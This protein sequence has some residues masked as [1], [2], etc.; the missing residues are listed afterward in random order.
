LSNVPTSPNQLLQS[1]IQYHQ[2]GRLAEAEQLY[3]K[4]LAQQPDHADALYLLGRLAAQVGRYG[5]AADLIGQA[6]ALRPDFPEAYCDLG[7]ALYGTGQLDEAICAYRQAIALRPQYA[8]AYSNLGDALKVKGQAEEAIAACRHAVVL[9]S[10][11]PEAHYNLG[12]ALTMKAR[13]DEAIIAYRQAIALRPNYPEAY[14]NLGVAL[15]GKGQLDE[16]IAA[17]R[18][19]LAQRPNY[20]EAHNNLGDAL[21]VKGQLDEAI[22]ACRQSIALRPANPDAYNNLGNALRLNGQLD[23]AIAAYRQAVALSPGNGGYHSNLVLTLGYHPRFDARALNDEAQIWSC[24]HA[25]PLRKCIRPHPNDRTPGRRLRIGYVSADFQVHACALFLEPLLRS[26]DQSQ[27]EVFCYSQVASPDSLTRRFQ[28]LCT[29]WRSTVGLSDAQVAD[30]VREDGID[31]LVDLKLHTDN[32]RLLVFARKPAPV[33]VTWLGYPGSTGMEAIDYRFSDPHLDPLG[34]DTSGYSEQT[35][36][37]PNTFWCYDPLTVEPA[38]NALPAIGAGHIIFGCLNNFSKV[39]E[40]ILGLWCRILRAIDGSKLL[41]LAPQGSVHQRIGDL[42]KR[43]GVQ[44]DRVEFAA[45]VSR[46]QYLELYH[47]VDLVLDTV[48]YNGHTT[49]LDGLW[50]GVPVVTLVGETVVGRAGLSQLT[51][52]G[53]PELIAHSADQYVQIA[54]SLANDLNRLAKLRSTLRLRMQQSPLMDAPRFARD[55]EAAYRQMWID[56][57]RAQS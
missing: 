2:R 9:R 15:C 41:L 29:A 44:P 35:I 8:D 14:G 22:A 26:H 28:S 34:T 10:N 37:L 31:I 33:L 51:N 32:N 47:R 19:A 4:V 39:N 40:Q 56:W 16:A 48:P 21:K 12:N 57:C 46:P 25:S 27:F 43:E 38:V 5:I 20:A 52:L 1:A 11:F 50:M 36:R 3:R 17:Y 24:R 6:V 54:T 42:L 7:V 30:L 23:E 13:L 45:R 49:T 53:L 18:Q 55:V